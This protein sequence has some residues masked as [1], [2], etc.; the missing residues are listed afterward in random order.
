MS[1]QDLDFREHERP[2][3]KII[4]SVPLYMLIVIQVA[5]TGIM[6][7]SAT[8]AISDYP[9]P[10]DPDF[11]LFKNSRFEDCL[12]STPTNDVNCTW[13]YDSALKAPLRLPGTVSDSPHFM[14]ELIYY[15]DA[16][17]IFSGGTEEWCRLTRCLS[18]FKVVPSSPHPSAYGF[19]GL[20][21]WFALNFMGLTGAFTIKKILH[22]KHS[23]DTCKGPALDD[24][25]LIVVDSVHLA[26]WWFNFSRLAVAPEHSPPVSLYAWVTPWRRMFSLYYHPYSCYFQG[27]SKW[28]QALISMFALV[29][30]MQWIAT[31]Y[32]TSLTFTRVNGLPHLVFLPDVFAQYDCLEDQIE[33][34]PGST[35]CSPD[36]ICSKEWLFG[37]PGFSR[38]DVTLTMYIIQMYYFLVF[39][40]MSVAGLFTLMTLWNPARW[41]HNIQIKLP[42][43]FVLSVIVAVAGALMFGFGAAIILGAGWGKL[44]REGTV[45]YDL[46]CHAL[47]VTISPWRYYMDVSD[48]TRPLRILKTYFNA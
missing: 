5:L 33:T 9:R 6:V 46:D 48:V 7:Y 27:D 10:E 44:N 12:L 35:T 40:Y 25:C 13:I 47:H 34:A 17:D 30:A 29:T 15:N 41:A 2:R 37:D 22:K 4:L 21:A 18:D 3:Y 45:A 20:D 39:L 11:S 43:I 31:I 42:K 38:Q 32:A 26:L 19:T 14:T 16:N 28:K 23:R 8:S 36:Q 24:W 1:R